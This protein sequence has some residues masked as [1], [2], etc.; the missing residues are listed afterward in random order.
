MPRALRHPLLQREFSHG[1]PATSRN[2]RSSNSPNAACRDPNGHRLALTTSAYRRQGTTPTKDRLR[3]VTVA[4]NPSVTPD[5]A[6]LDHLRPPG[7]VIRD[8]AR[9][10]L[11]CAVRGLKTLA[12]QHFLHVGVLED[13]SQR[14]IEA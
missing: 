14:L 12:L 8:H 1:F 11:G 2:N 7:D 5:V 13:A 10:L 9:K 3:T 6:D 4:A